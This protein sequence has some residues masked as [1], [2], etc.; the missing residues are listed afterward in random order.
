MAR[1]LIGLDVGT[2]AVTVAEV[3]SGAPA[4][5]RAFGQVALPRDA[6]DEGEVVDEAAVAEAVGRLRAEVGLRKVPVRLGVASPRVIVRQVEMP[7]MSKED[8]AGAL[9]FQ[10]QELIPIPIDDAVLDFVILEQGTVSEA[11]PDGEPLM[12]VLLAAAQRVTVERL[13]SAVEGGGFPVE[14]VDLVPLAL[15]RALARPAT[16]EAGAE[17]IVSFGG[18]VTCVTIHEQGV[19]RF[20]RVLGTGG[21]ELTDA[22]TSELELPFESAESIKRQV[23]T[24]NDESVV[25]ARTAMERPL[26]FLLDEVRSSIDYYRNQPGAARLLRVVTTGGGAQLPGINDR[27]ASLVGVPVEAARPRELLA[28]GDIGFSEDELPGLDPYLPAA[29]GLAL[30]GSDR[31]I[32]IDLSPQR[33]RRRRSTTTSVSRSRTVAGGAAAAAVLVAL[34]AVPTLAR[35]NEIN[36]AKDERDTV[37]A[38][39][40]RIQNDIQQL[41]EAQAKADQLDALEAQLNTLLASDVSWARMLQEIS[42]TIPNDVWLTSF[43]ATLQQGPV[44]GVGT[45]VP[46]ED[47]AGETTDTP[48]A[49]PVTPAISGTVSITANGL[50]FP[51]VAAW[52]QRI[53]SMPSFADIW[54]PQANSAT[55]NEREIVTFTSTGTIT[56]AARSNR[57]EQLTQEDG[58]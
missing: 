39:N 18:G 20:V 44:G 47:T 15:V 57:L 56:D 2:N 14:A 23:G 25:R 3:S 43:Q 58:Q 42:R 36:D 32:V 16:G 34:L 28:V 49:P 40:T 54:V 29:V 38:Q 46:T 1:R 30:G 35:Q 31:G 6:M 50:G 8:L 21:R 12:R 24:S 13:V 5:L 9:R 51:S 10:A 27:L 7:V 22:I 33:G 17:G 55:E 53:A 37:L 45:T 48:T 19:P 11:E 52:L 4:S 26:G 41:S